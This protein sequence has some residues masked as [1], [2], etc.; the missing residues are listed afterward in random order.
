MLYTI[1]IYIYILIEKRPALNLQ[2]C[3]YLNTINYYISSLSGFLHDPIRKSV[4]ITTG[5]S[6]SDIIIN[7]QSIGKYNT[8]LSMLKHWEWFKNQKLKIELCLLAD[9]PVDS[10]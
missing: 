10:Y 6:Q 3:T 4:Y 5:Q 1:L 8:H 9:P 7:N 2:L